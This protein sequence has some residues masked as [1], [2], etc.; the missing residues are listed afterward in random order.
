MVRGKK[1]KV[2]LTNGGCVKACRSGG[3]KSINSVDVVA[4]GDAI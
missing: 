4:R 1:M 2:L 3:G